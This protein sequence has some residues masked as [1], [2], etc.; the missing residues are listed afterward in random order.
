MHKHRKQSPQ[1]NC[2]IIEMNTANT[3]TQHLALYDVYK[4]ASKM[5]A[6]FHPPTTQWYHDA[7]RLC[8]HRTA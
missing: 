7:V 2:R 3:H 4:C 5:A 6:S 8:R 1:M